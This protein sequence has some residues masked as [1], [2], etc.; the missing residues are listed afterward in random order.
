[1]D[2]GPVM[3]RE[4]NPRRSPRMTGP[5]ITVKEAAAYLHVG[6]DTIYEACAARGMKHSK[7]GHSTIRLRREWVDAWAETQTRQSS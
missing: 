1:M 6:V 7:I 4:P 3:T 2:S 5:W